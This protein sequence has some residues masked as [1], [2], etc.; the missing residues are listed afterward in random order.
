M[1]LGAAVVSSD[2][3]RALQTAEEVMQA[4]RLHGQ[5]LIEQARVQAQQQAEQL[6]FESVRDAQRQ[7]WQSVLDE[8]ESFRLARQQ[9]T[10]SAYPLMIEVLSLA[11]QQLK[12]ELPCEHWIRSSVNLTLQEWAGDQ[13]AILRVHPDDRPVVDGLVGQRA[14]LRVHE[15]A[16]LSRGQCELSGGSSLLRADFAGGIDALTRAL[17]PVESPPHS[18]PPGGQPHFFE[19]QE[20]A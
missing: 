4:S 10:E 15:D 6:V 12:L 16:T 13:D 5:A 9:W 11:M 17:D 20:Q 1:S 3:L 18:Q 8:W 14:F 19:L 2:C 7:V